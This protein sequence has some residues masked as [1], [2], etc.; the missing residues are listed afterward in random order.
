MKLSKINTEIGKLIE[1]VV[2]EEV[3][4]AMNIT[5]G[6]CDKCKS[7]EC[8]CGINESEVAVCESCGL[9]ETE[10]KCPV[11]E[12]ET[13]VEEGN[14]F[15]DALSKAKEAG[16]EEFD[17]DGK[18][19]PV[20][21]STKKVLRLTESDLIELVEKLVS[22]QNVPGIDTYKK[23]HKESGKHNKDNN[24]LV[25]KKMKEYTDIEG[26]T[27]NEFP[28]QTGGEIKGERVEK[29]EEL[30]FIEDMK[31]GMQALEYDR[32]PEN[33]EE[34]T[35]KQLKGDST[36]GNAQFDVFGEPLGNVVPTE[37]GEKVN[38][39]RKREGLAKEKKKGYNTF[40]QKVETVN[41]SM[42]ND[43]VISDMKKMKK[44]VDYTKKTQ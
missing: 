36:Q 4:K 23:S 5:E 17:V 15:T 37:T 11:S 14:K 41:E 44:L 42:I 27:G 16:E 28:I 18:T 30:E 9:N 13:D 35:E 40:P 20:K 6:G 10:C 38:K 34:K 25:T 7:G 32:T 12:S 33:F 19:Y 29:D 31:G 8:Q 1:S 24:D 2:K 22:E 26:N 39:T 3:L 21:E 43:K